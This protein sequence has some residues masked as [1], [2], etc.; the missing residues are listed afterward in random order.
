M[1]S[2]TPATESIAIGHRRLQPLS[3]QKKTG[4]DAISPHG[5]D[6]RRQPLPPPDVRPPIPTERVATRPPAGTPEGNRMA[7]TYRNS[8]PSGTVHTDT[9]VSNSQPSQFSISQF[10]I[11]RI[12]CSH[13]PQRRTN[14]S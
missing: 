7:A 3:P 6:H 13:P 14:P 12:G 8:A 11:R 5:T 10:S 1:L 9:P 2:Q 4:N